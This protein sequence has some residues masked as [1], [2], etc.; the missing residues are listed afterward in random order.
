MT[1]S[2]HFIFSVTLENYLLYLEAKLKEFPFGVKRV[3]VWSHLEGWKAQWL[4]EGSLNHTANGDGGFPSA[5]SA[6]HL[7]TRSLRET[8]SHP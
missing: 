8:S 6:P 5:R 3:R 1:L 4:V 7:V 2:S